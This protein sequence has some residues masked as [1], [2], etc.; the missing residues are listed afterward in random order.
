M[1]GTRHDFAFR[2]LTFTARGWTTR[3]VDFL[4]ALG[5]VLVIEGLLFAALPNVAREAMRAAA[6]SPADR[7]ADRRILSA[8]GGIVL[9]WLARGD[10]DL[11]LTVS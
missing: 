3:H 11:G 1:G 6:E 5:L 7:N 4:T 9:I 2:L 8:V 10:P